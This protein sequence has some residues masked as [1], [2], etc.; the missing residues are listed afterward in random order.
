MSSLPR[1][2]SQGYPTTGVPHI[3]KMTINRAIGIFVYIQQE[4][5]RKYLPP[6]WFIIRIYM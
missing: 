3:F 4:G 1:P 5:E 2:K 6:E